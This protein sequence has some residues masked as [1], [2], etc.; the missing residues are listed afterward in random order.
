[1]NL[2]RMPSNGLNYSEGR[3]DLEDDPRSGLPSTARNS[4]RVSKVRELMRRDCPI[5]VTPKLI[6]CHGQ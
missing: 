1:M 4:E 5:P 3:E 6:H 2:V